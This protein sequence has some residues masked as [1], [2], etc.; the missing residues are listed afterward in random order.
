MPTVIDEF[1]VEFGLDPAKF[2]EGQKKLMEAMRRTQS[3]AEQQA[4][5]ME[6]SGGKISDSLSI[7][8]RKALGFASVLL[9]GVGLTHFAEE[10]IHSDFHLGRFAKTLGMLPGE[11]NQWRTAIR[12]AGG[13]TNEVDQAFSHIRDQLQAF[14]LTGTN[15]LLPLLNAMQ[16]GL[17]KTANATKNPA[18]YFMS[19]ADV[20]HQ[21]G[22]TDSARAFAVAERA[23]MSMTMFQIAVDKGRAGF[24]EWLSMAQRLNP[25]TDAN[26]ASATKLE[27]AWNKFAVSSEGIGN[28]IMRNLIEPL[29][30][31]LLEELTSP[32]WAKNFNKALDANGGEDDKTSLGA[33]SK[34]HKLDKMY[35]GGG[36]DTDE[37]TKTY[38]KAAAIA[39]GIDPQVALTVAANEGLGKDNYVG[40]RGTSFGPYQL[41]YDGKSVGDAFTKK[42][43]LDARDPNTTRQQIDFALDWAKAH[44]WTDWH[45]W[46]G[47]QWAGI[48]SEHSGGQRTEIKVNTMNVNLPGVRNAEEFS[49]T[50]P[51]IINRQTKGSQAATSGE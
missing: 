38:I 46:K 3:A 19:I 41:H 14:N 29:A 6:E 10:V 24:A 34:A 43:G 16:V 51:S 17:L 2:T 27:N 11:V 48:G 21:L 32:D 8:T 12:L 47:A 50:I 40:D 20:I 25:V 45:G 18:E 35:R 36:F 49:N 31:P 15:D 5:G 33:R 4:K 9:G 1:V 13:D 22:K 26:V 37:A 30:V 28:A 23:G 42:T 39:R 7:I 44:G